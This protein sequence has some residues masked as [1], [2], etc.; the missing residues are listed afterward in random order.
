[1]YA[2]IALRATRGQ[3]ALI[4]DANVTFSLLKQE[5]QCCSSAAKQHICK[6]LVRANPLPSQAT[7]EPAYYS[8]LR[9]VWLW[10]RM[11]QP[12]SADGRSWPEPCRDSCGVTMHTIVAV[13][14][15]W[16]ILHA[17]SLLHVEKS[18]K[19]S[20]PQQAIDEDVSCSNWVLLSHSPRTGRD[21]VLSMSCFPVTPQPL[22]PC[23]EAVLEEWGLL[24][25]TTPRWLDRAAWDLTTEANSRTGKEAVSGDHI[26][27][28]S[29]GREQD[30][31]GDFW[32][33]EID[34]HHTSL[35]PPMQQQVPL[36]PLLPHRAAAH[37]T[38]TLYLEVCTA[39]ALL[40]TCWDFAQ[41]GSSGLKE[42][43]Q[44]IRSVPSHILR[45]LPKY[46]S[47]LDWQT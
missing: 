10:W 13:L 41:V 43:L 29:Q 36:T 11:E 21:A 9:Y 47:S 22:H 20:G 30:P 27:T 35:F 46:F 4:W 28:S 7:A 18:T 39:R 42:P 12:S 31:Y 3:R 6:S 26:P 40:H 23:Q 5:K 19:L 45:L 44:V 8:R 34:C 17:P 24:P 16:A 33:E 14:P 32:L 25:L 2:Y 37:P 38:P 15:L 1:M